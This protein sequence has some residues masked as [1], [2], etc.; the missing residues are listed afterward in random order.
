[1][2]QPV[3]PARY[4]G[5]RR[6]ARSEARP[7]GARYALRRPRELALSPLSSRERARLAEPDRRRIVG[8]HRSLPEDALASGEWQAAGDG[9]NVWRMSIRSPGS[10]GIRVEFRDF[11]VGGGKV[12]L[13]AAGQV[14]GPYT[15]RGLYD[16]GRFWSSTI[17][18]DTVTLEYEPASAIEGTR[19]AIRF[20][21]LTVPETRIT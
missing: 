17:F 5:V 9:S 12:W 14:A 7:P 8:L 21:C 18:A 10:E 11:S 20:L 15:G 19:K 2:A 16:N 1:M 3:A 4:D 6:V 13:H